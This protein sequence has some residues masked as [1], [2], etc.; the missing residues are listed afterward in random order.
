MKKTYKFTILFLLSGLLLQSCQDDNDDVIK[1]TDLEVQDF[2]WKGMNLYYL[3]Q[4][5]VPNLADDRFANQAGLDAF[6]QGY[7]EPENLFNALRVD[8]SIDRFSWIV[9]DYRDLEG[10]L[11]GI[12]K[13][14][15]LDFQ[16]AYKTQGSDDIYGYVR[17]ILPNSD[18]AAKNVTR[19][20]V[21][22]GINGTQLNVSNY[23]SLLS[24]DTYTLNLADYNDGLVTPNGKSITLTKAVV[25]ENPIFI[26]KVLTVGTH[27]IGYLMYN[28]FFNE[29]DLELNDA[30][31]EFKSAQV[32]DFV[33]DLRYNGGGSILTATRLASMIYGE[34][35]GKIFAKQEWNAKL[36]DYFKSNNPE[37]LN[38]YFTD[39]IDKTTINSLNLN[40]VYILT[41]PNTASA[42]ELVINGLKPF[43]NVV[44]IGGTTVGKNVGSVTIYDSPT[45]GKTNINPNHRYAMQPLVLRLVNAAGFGEYTSG[46][47]PNIAI[48]ETASNLGV[49]GDKEEPFLKATINVITGGSTARTS[50][51]NNEKAAIYFKDTKTM[52][53]QNQMFIDEAPEGLL[54]AL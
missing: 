51:P 47:L 49:L 23:T 9:D 54:K 43:V 41:S 25:A 17:Y 2:I 16:L 3:W 1:T 19:G 5:D 10:A 18:A 24:N 21:F 26:K 52:N 8:K 11:G 50:A 28:G 15:G 53:G 31:G 30:F 38:N 45:F 33:L 29:Y 34:G 7:S 27:K 48:N 4:A 36:N 35:K 44:Q 13:N 46:L 32:T 39:K 22:Y 20:T 12:T 42:S 6:L 40:K 37:Q 14:N